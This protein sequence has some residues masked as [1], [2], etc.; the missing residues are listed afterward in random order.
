MDTFL[1]C[2]RSC[3]PKSIKEIRA[4]SET[5]CIEAV[6]VLCC[7][8]LLVHRELKVLYLRILLW[9]VHGM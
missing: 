9:I 3:S 6:E 7:D 1:H 5:Q 8:F 2:I 4:L